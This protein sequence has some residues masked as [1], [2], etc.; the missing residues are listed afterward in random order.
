MANKYIIG[1][2]AVEYNIAGILIP[3]KSYSD[4]EQR[5]GKKAYTEVDETQ[6][7]VLQN[8]KVFNTLLENKM[9]RILDHIPNFALSGEDRANRK[10]AEAEKKYT[11]EIEQLKAEL[12]AAKAELKRSKGN[13]KS[14]GTDEE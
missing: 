5:R 4:F 1:Y 10:F 9:V 6:L 12:E 11:S 13:N 3:K 7:A 2:T 8:D 14:S